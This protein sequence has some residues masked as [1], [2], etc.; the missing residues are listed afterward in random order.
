[1]T[2]ILSSPGQ[3]HLKC[4]ANTC[5]RTRTNPAFRR[6]LAIASCNKVGQASCLSQLFRVSAPL[7]CFQGSLKP[8]QAI[9]CSPLKPNQ[10]KSNHFKPN[11]SKNFCPFRAGNLGPRRPIR[12]IH[13]IPEMFA[14][15][16]NLLIGTSLELESLEPGTFVYDKPL[17]TS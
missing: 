17:Q 1:M 3:T 7:R 14:R 4:V 10:T 2:E 11:Q 12:Y 9:A 15:P 13:P 16:W 8:N 5:V 6:A